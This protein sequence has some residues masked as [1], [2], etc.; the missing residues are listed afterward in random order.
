MERF[1]RV[2]EVATRTG[3]SIRTLH[4]YDRIGLL[5]P[6]H[7]SP[8]GYRLY[9]TD[10]LPRLQQI[11]TLRLL[12]FSLKQI[13]AL[14]ERRDF[15]L[16]ASLRIQR[17]VVRDRIAELERIDAALD[18]LVAHRLATGEWAWEL[19]IAASAAVHDGLTH[20][21][22]EM[23]A[24]YTPEQ[25][26]QFAEVGAAVPQAE[27]TAIETA[28]AALL[29]EIRA[30]PDHDPASDEARAL[31]D[32]WQELNTRTMQHYQTHPELMEAI[33][34]NYDRGAFEGNTL[35]PQAAD[36]A[37][38]ERVNAARSETDLP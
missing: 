36:F 28:W 20:K 21:G 18:A 2:G 3:V 34:A 35:A 7:H 38:I 9:A 23:E 27:I 11:L 4:H 32:R 14:L 5:R 33:R 25:I 6:A 22:E 17:R 24:H 30:D 26:H 29:T 15:D 10:D 19:A 1:Y 13:G 8:A 12:G 31:A 37:F 16:V